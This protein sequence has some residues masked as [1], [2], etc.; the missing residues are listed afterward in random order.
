MG[1]ASGRGRSP[2]LVTGGEEEEEEEE[3]EERVAQTLQ[4]LISC[5]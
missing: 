4:P 3:E 1:V 5:V 2:L